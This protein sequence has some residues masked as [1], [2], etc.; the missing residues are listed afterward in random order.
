MLL[1]TYDVNPALLAV[2]GLVGFL[3]FKWISYKNSNYYKWISKLPGPK[4][5]PLIGNSMDIKGGYAGEYSK[6]KIRGTNCAVDLFIGI[7]TLTFNFCP[8]I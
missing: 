8:A 5:L 4:P 3:S 7:L 1:F 6:I 2:A